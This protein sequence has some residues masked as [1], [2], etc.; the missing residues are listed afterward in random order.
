MIKRKIGTNARINGISVKRMKNRYM[1]ILKCLLK[2]IKC[3]KRFD[4]KPCRYRKATREAT[5]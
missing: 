1:R 5:I 2:K 4:G 3:E